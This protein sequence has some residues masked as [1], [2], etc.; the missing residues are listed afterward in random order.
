M[1]GT[2]YVLSQETNCGSEH[3]L[4]YD[5]YSGIL[6]NVAWVIAAVM[7]HVA[8]ECGGEVYGADLT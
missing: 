4:L 8:H 2:Y 1:A 7:K 6:L 5:V 3:P